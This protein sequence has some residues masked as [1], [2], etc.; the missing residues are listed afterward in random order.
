MPA[1]IIVTFTTIP[2]RL[3]LLGPALAALAAQKRRPD[4]VELYLP[5]TW[6]RFPGERPALPALPDWLTV[7]DTPHDL[8]PATKVLPAL[9]RHRGRN[10]DILFCD[11][12][13]THDPLWTTRFAALRAERPEDVVCEYGVDLA[14]LCSDPGLVPQDRPQ[15]RALVNRVSAARISASLR[16]MAT[17]GAGIPYLRAPGYVDV[18]FGFRGALLRPGWLDPRATHLPDVVWTVDD[19][20]LSG[21]AALA[22]RRIWAGGAASWMQGAAPAA[23][24]GDLTRHC[25]IGIGRDAANRLCVDYLRNR[26]GVWR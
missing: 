1:P 26:Y 6:R 3:P 21:M 19:V 23:Q 7:V 13:M 10:V 2:P 5:R 22:G 9:D 12:D 20:W 11:D 16:S 14:D 24:V 17:G 8:G 18:L 15:P 4:A 25:E